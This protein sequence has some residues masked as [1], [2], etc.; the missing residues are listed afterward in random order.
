MWTTDVFMSKHQIRHH[1]RRRWDIFIKDIC[2]NKLLIDLFLGPSLNATYF[3]MLTLK[4]H[5]YV[6][7][8]D[9]S[10]LS[11][12]TEFLIIIYIDF[13]VNLLFL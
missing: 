1:F 6:F 2:Y 11:L 12:L 7:A 10:Y 9:C 5:I 8:Q 13:R 4:R 3:F